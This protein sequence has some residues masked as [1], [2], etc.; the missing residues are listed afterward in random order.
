MRAVARGADPRRA[1]RAIAN[2]PHARCERFKR[3]SA[4]R[5]RLIAEGPT[6][7]AELARWRPDLDRAQWARRVSAAQAERHL[8]AGAGTG[9]AGQGAVSRAARIVRYNVVMKPLVGNHYGLIVR[10]ETMQSAA[11][12]LDKLAVPYEVRVVS[13][14]RTPD[15][16]FEYASAARGAGT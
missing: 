16:L 1:R 14:H 9:A 6:A 4:W 15:L 2:V 8:A 10:L 11:E 5:E 7:L 13:A 12:V 3:V